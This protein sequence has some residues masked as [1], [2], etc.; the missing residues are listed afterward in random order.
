HLDGGAPD[1]DGSGRLGRGGSRRAGGGDRHPAR[2]RRAVDR[3]GRALAAG[4]RGR[5]PARLPGDRGVLAHA[6]RPRGRRR[7]APGDLP[8][9]VQ[10]RAGPAPGLGPALRG[11]AGVRLLPGRPAGAVPADPE[12]ARR[13]GSAEPVD[14]ADRLGRVRGPAG[15]RR[16]R[17]PRPGRA[18]VAA[19]FVGWSVGPFSGADGPARRPCW[20]PAANLP[21]P[22]EVL[23]SWPDRCSPA[24]PPEDAQ[25]PTTAGDHRWLASTSRMRTPRDP[26]SWGSTSA[27]AAH[28]PPS[29]T[30]RPVR[31]ASGSTRRPTPSR[32][33]TT[34]PAPSTPIRSSR[35]SAP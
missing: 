29:T 22:C 18:R 35:R 10:L 31:S 8:P 26:W 34:A 20:Q 3:R 30:P 2:H 15:L 4:L 7:R 24:L 5:L 23:V 1:P 19:W 27:P 13:A 25:L 6:A 28:A 9:P 33:T 17:A 12:T 14:D 21:V 11:G 16:G 32:S